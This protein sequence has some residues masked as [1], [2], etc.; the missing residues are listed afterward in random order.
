MD[1]R[2]C[3]RGFTFSFC[4]Y[5]GQ[6]RQDKTDE[7]RGSKALLYWDVIG[8]RGGMLGGGLAALVA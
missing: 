5:D 1:G 3:V 4:M 6:T 8:V 7:L 2:A